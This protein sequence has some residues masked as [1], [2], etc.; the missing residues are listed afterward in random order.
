MYVFAVLTGGEDDCS[1][2][3]GVFANSYSESRAHTTSKPDFTLEFFP[4]LNQS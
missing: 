1:V 2:N 3:V 4:G